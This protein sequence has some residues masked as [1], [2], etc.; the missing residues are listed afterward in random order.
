MRRHVQADHRQLAVR[1]GQRGGR[2]DP[3]PPVLGAERVADLPQVSAGQ[4]RGKDLKQPEQQAADST[5][6]PE[7]AVERPLER[8]GQVDHEQE[9][10]RGPAHVGPCGPAPGHGQPDQAR[11]HQGGH[12]GDQ[13]VLGG[14]QQPQHPR[15]RCGDHDGADQGQ[16]EAPHR[17]PGTGVMLVPPRGQEQGRRAKRCGHDRR[18]QYRLKHSS[19]HRMR[20]RGRSRFRAVTSGTGT[21]R[22]LCTETSRESPSRQAGKRAGSFGADKYGQRC[23]RSVY[24]GRLQHDVE[25]RDA[26]RSG[27]AV[28]GRLFRVI[29]GR[30]LARCEWIQQSRPRFAHT[31]PELPTSPGSLA[32]R[33]AMMTTEPRHP[34]SA[35]R[36]CGVP[37]LCRRA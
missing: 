35:A 34:A 31:A 19:P 5:E 9:Y 32:T 11:E 8:V 13:V 20:A 6:G 15:G 16:G 10:A 2:R 26:E 36:T 12:S 22:T 25:I 30:E 3:A 21:I 33:A 4:Q 29:D 17:R 23:G 18:E 7:V 37:E 1:H 24:R 14:P 27:Q 28:P